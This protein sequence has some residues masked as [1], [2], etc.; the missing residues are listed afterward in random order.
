MRESP[1]ARRLLLHLHFLKGREVDVMTS[2]EVLLFLVLTTG[3]IIV[4]KKK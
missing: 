3:Y 1:Q 4:L 2:F